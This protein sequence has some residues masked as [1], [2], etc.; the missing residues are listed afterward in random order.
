MARELTRTDTL[1]SKIKKMK[2][3]TIILFVL[4]IALVATECKKKRYPSDIP[5]WLK[6]KIDKMEKDS[7]GKGCR[8]PGF[9]KTIE[10][11]SDG[12]STYYWL[13]VDYNPTTYDVYDYNGQVVC[14]NA[15]D[16]SSKP[17]CGNIGYGK[18]FIRLVWE[19]N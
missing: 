4:L 17:P 10:E 3:L 14:Y 19:E 15:Y 7:K 2:K 13:T 16:P 5:K 1:K 9:C 8:I 18:N 12:S 6:E 11:Y